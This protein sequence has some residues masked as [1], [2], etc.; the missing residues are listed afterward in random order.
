MA[1]MYADYLSGTLSIED[2]MAKFQERWE[3]Y[4]RPVSAAAERHVGLRAPWSGDLR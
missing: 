3:R 2:L 4:L 1:T